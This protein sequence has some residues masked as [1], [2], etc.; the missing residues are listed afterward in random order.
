MVC[1]VFPPTQREWQARF[2]DG[3]LFNA[4]P[5]QFLDV[6]E[7]EALRATHFG[8]TLVGPVGPTSARPK[9]KIDGLDLPP[10]STFLDLTLGKTVVWDGETFRD[11]ATAEAV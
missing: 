11:P 7:T 1:R 6:T 5:G 8:W 9:S 3:R 4:K 10:G 2:I